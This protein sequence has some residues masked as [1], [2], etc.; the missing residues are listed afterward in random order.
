M[1]ITQTVD[2][3]TMIGT[4][5]GSFPYIIEPYG[6]MSKTCITGEI[7]EVDDVLMD[8]LDKLEAN[9]SRKLIPL[10]NGMIACAYIL[11]T[12]E[13]L[14]EIITRIGERFV[15]VPGGDWKEFMSVR[16]F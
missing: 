12:Q 10:T 11:D 6:D 14:R 13:L 8:K 2:T 1:G 3:Y 9:Y 7:Y 4:R 16:Q 15:L 5:Y